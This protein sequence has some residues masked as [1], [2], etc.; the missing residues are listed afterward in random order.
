MAAVRQ[1]VVLN[2]KEIRDALL[3]RAKDAV[4]GKPDG[5]NIVGSS[6]VK[7]LMNGGD[8]KDGY[9]AEVVFERPGK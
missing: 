7:L 9:S 2:D 8:G 3:E 6:T 1:V 5:P 4:N